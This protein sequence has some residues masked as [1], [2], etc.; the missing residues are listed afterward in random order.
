MD[1]LMMVRDELEG[2]MAAI[3]E[4]HMITWRDVLLCMRAIYIITGVII[5]NAKKER[6]REK[7]YT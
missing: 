6:T 4:R 5:R 3:E 1:D 7:E 2:R